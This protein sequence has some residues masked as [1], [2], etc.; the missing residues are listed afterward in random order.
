[1]YFDPKKTVVASDASDSG[2]KPVAHMSRS[3]IAAEKNYSQ[4]EKG[5][6]TIIFALKK[7]HRFLHKRVFSSH[8]ST[9]VRYC[10]YMVQRRVFLH[11]Q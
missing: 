11:V 8:K 6:L 10:L 5:A 2:I 4:V 7:F 1:M 3:L 9:I